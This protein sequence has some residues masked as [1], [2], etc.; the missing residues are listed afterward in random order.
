MNLGFPYMT[1]DIDGHAR[2]IFI[3]S[4]GAKTLERIMCPWHG[5]QCVSQCAVF[6]VA[7]HARG[8]H[9]FVCRARVKPI[10]LGIVDEETVSWDRLKNLELGS[11][12][13]KHER[14]EEKTI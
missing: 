12:I 6:G 1:I 5:Q 4:S 7:D 10:I 9:A 2:R 3:D 14:T 11:D 13:A 8:H